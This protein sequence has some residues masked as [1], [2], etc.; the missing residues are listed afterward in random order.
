MISYST[1]GRAN[2]NQA[3]VL[4][5]GLATDGRIFKSIVKSYL[6]TKYFVVVPDLRGCGQSA[7]TSGEYTINESANDIVEIMK[8]VG[9]EKYLLFGYSQGGTIAQEIAKSRPELISGLII[10]N[11]FA[12]NT[13]TFQ[14]KVESYLL[15]ITIR[16]LPL[17]TITR[18]L[19][20]QLKKEGVTDEHDLQIFEKSV[21]GCKKLAIQKYIKELRDFDSSTWLNHIK[22]KTLVVRGQK[23]VAVPAHH[24]L[25]LNRL[26]K[27]S[28]LKEI[29]GA[30][31]AM[32][33]THEASLIEII[34]DNEDFLLDGRYL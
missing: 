22:C 31:H 25:E 18:L 34:K 8:G 29:E 32:L 24:A 17:A 28:I 33:W 5:H 3:I 13:R 1:Y 23:D 27:N 14:E 2:A 4:I 19:K 10:V 26:I 16:I 21:L 7:R 15:G 11:S 9:K 12:N 6:A 30:G 20:S